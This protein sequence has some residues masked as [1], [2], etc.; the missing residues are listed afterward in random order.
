MK[1]KYLFRLFILKRKKR[2]TNIL[3]VLICV[4]IWTSNSIWCH[5][6][7]RGPAEQ[8]RTATGRGGLGTSGTIGSE[9]HPGARR[10]VASHQ[11]P[12][13]ALQTEWGTGPSRPS[14]TPPPASSS[15]VS[16][17]QKGFYSSLSPFIYSL[18]PFWK[19]SQSSVVWCSCSP[20]HW[21]VWVQ[22]LAGS[23]QRQKKWWTLGL[24]QTWAKSG[25]MQ[26]IKKH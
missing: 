25:F 5:R 20:W 11:G 24:R 3:I 21:N 12:T 18:S 19:K 13:P 2:Q 22:I 8:L 23:Y 1:L 7:I 14:L 6:P 4:P 26:G 17:L 16:P 10:H 9:G 15:L